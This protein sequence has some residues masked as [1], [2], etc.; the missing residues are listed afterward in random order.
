MNQP[1]AIGVDIGGTLIRVGAFDSDGQLLGQNEA[2]IAF[3]GPDNGLRLIEQLIRETLDSA[4]SGIQFGSPRAINSNKFSVLIHAIPTSANR[5]N[6]LFSQRYGSANYEEVNIFVNFTTSTSAGEICFYVQGT[7]SAT[8]VTIATS[9]DSAD[10]KPH[11]IVGTSTAVNAAPKI[12]IDGKND[13]DYEQHSASG[14]CFSA[15]QK[16]TIGNLGDYTG[17]GFA[18]L[19]SPVFLVLVWNDRELSDSE[20]MAISADPYQFLIPA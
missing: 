5:A 6:T 3:I 14:N 10:G 9:Y 2:N 1:I 13:T 18:N 19:D 20:G 4:N 11:V 17:T 16:L 15:N 7:G 12:Y 8:N